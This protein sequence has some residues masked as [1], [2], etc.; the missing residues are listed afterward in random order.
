M[1]QVGSKQSN[2]YLHDC[3]RT[4]RGIL[5]HRYKL[6]VMALCLAD[7][8][9]GF[10]PEV[11]CPFMCHK[12]LQTL[13]RWGDPDQ[14]QIKVRYQN[15]ICCHQHMGALTQTSCAWD[16]PCSGV[17]L[18]AAGSGPQLDM[19]HHSCIM[20]INVRCQEL[21]FYLRFM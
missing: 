8:A 15:K 20:G 4:G 5:R 11:S 18:R 1:D 7:K 17:A 12:S 13:Q 2:P 9:V 3:G 21:C 19:H 14:S 6:Q 16:Q 10:F